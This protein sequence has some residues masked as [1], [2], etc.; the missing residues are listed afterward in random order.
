M[1]FFPKGTP[2]LRLLPSYKG[3]EIIWKWLKKNCQNQ[4]DILIWVLFI[5]T[6]V[7]PDF[8]YSS[9]ILVYTLLW[10]FLTEQ[11]TSARL[12]GISYEEHICLKIATWKH[13][14]WFKLV[15]V[16]LCW[17]TSA[18]TFVKCYIFD[19]HCTQAHFH[20]PQCLENLVRQIGI[21]K[22]K[23]FNHEIC[24]LWFIIPQM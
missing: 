10:E 21:V 6:T 7:A 12:P 2:W 9:L 22:G 1:I 8:C 19:R 20:T 14:Y 17:Y 13:I 3:M 23:C 18:T 4:K 15:G 5:L 16:W 11:L 24:F